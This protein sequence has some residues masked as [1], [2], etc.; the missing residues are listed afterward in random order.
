MYC[1]C[2][3]SSDRNKECQLMLFL[4]LY[5]PHLQ[6]HTYMHN[7]GSDDLIIAVQPLILNWFA[8]M[9]VF[10]HRCQVSTV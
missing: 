1:S 10:N 3:S 6:L 5:D 7:L 8:E 4:V 2:G 9:T